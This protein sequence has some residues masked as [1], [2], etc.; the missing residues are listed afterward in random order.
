MYTNEQLQATIEQH[1]ARAKSI[2]THLDYVDTLPDTPGNRQNK[3][4]LGVLLTD[5][6]QIISEM[7]AAL[8]L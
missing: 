1:T 4:R 3:M 2:Q 7:Q 8:L 5:F 6:D